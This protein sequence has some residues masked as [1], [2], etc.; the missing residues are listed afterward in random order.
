MKVAVIGLGLVGGSLAR[1]LARAGHYV[2]G[3]DRSAATL[4]AARRA[5][6]V[7]EGLGSGF[8][9][10]RDCDVC[11]IAVPVDAGPGVL[12]AARAEL[13]HVPLVI[14]VGSTKRSIVRAATQLGLGGRF[15]G[16]HPLAGDHRSGW[17]ASRTGLFAGR[18]V[19]LTPSPESSRD[20]LVRARRLWRAVGARPEVLTAAAHD[21]LLARTSHLP[22]MVSS[23]LALA[24]AAARVPRNAVGAGGRDTTRIAGSDPSVWAAILADNRD[25][26]VRAL[27]AYRAALSRLERIIAAGNTGALRREL[28]QARAWA[29][30]G[31]G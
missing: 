24:L 3:H 10:L 20:A 19:F 5:R 30:R 7:R 11:V 12:A 28:R 8:A 14:D 2:L 31:T 26:V 15:V 18:R 21:A 13:A 1:D 4:R 22:Q 23:A 6:V 17:R 27:A 29:L 9:G 16:A 25:H